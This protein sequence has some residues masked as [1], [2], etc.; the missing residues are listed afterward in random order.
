MTP[1]VLFYMGVVYERPVN[2]AETVRSQAKHERCQRDRVG[3]FVLLHGARREATEPAVGNMKRNKGK[4]EDADGTE[5]GAMDGPEGRG[6]WRVDRAAGADDGGDPQRDH[7]GG[8]GLPVLR[9]P[10]ARARLRRRPAPGDRRPLQHLTPVC[11]GEAT[12][13]A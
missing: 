6:R 2:R 4:A 3:I 1:S 11:R 8:G 10:A 12:A 7:A 5:S 9:G 13:P